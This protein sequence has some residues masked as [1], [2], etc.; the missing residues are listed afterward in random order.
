MVKSSRCDDLHNTK[1]QMKLINAI[2]AAAVLAC[3]TLIPSA[4]HAQYSER[5]QTS[6]FDDLNGNP[7][8]RD[9]N[10]TTYRHSPL[11]EEDGIGSYQLRGNDG[12]TL[13]CSRGFSTDR[14]EE[15]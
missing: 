11:Y 9:S 5:L 1:I 12:S 8:Y 13:R 15:Y 7:T 2:A 10:G 4:V 3:G 6:P 14:C